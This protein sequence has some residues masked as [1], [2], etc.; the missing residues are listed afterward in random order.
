MPTAI[1]DLVA[2]LAIDDS[3]WTAGLAKGTSDLKRFDEN[4]QTH[5]AG[6][7]RSMHFL[8]REFESAGNQVGK[9]SEAGGEMLTGLGE[10][11][12]T[13]GMAEH[14]AHALGVAYQWAASRR[15]RPVRSARKVYSYGYREARTPTPRHLHG[16]PTVRDYA[17]VPNS[18]I[19]QD[20]GL[21]PMDVMVFIVLDLHTDDGGNRHARKCHR[22]RPHPG[23]H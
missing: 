10:G 5:V 23:R 17:I 19:D 6:A 20:S 16:G 8:G 2:N 18:M 7:Y 12:S 14:S 15:A 1:G 21:S 9:F 13:L 22:L 4:A 3:R 11:I